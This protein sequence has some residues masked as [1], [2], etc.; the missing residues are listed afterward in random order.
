MT[1]DYLSV[2]HVQS[3]N[4]PELCNRT[5]LKVCSLKLHLIEAV[6]LTWRAKG[7]SVFMIFHD[8]KELSFQIQVI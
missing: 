5:Y 8:S 4:A 7:E 2:D 6:V 1:N 3:V